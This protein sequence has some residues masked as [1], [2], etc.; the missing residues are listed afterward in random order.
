MFVKLIQLKLVDTYRILAA[1]FTG[2][3]LNL[4]A[5]MPKSI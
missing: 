2:Y 1:S 5:L 3:T 4:V